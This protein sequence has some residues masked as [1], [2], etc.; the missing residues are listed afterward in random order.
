MR[1]AIQVVLDSSLALVAIL[2]ILACLGTVLANILSGGTH[3]DLDAHRKT[4]HAPKP[5]HPTKPKP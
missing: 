3:E 2:I 4:R 5:K 1:E